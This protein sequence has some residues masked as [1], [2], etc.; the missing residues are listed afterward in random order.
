MLQALKTELTT[1]PLGRGY[2]G[3][4]NTQVVTSL[5]T[6]NRTVERRS[7]SGSQ[8]YNAIVPSEFS[9][10]LA[11]QQQLVRDVFGL[12]D[13]IDVRTGTNARAVMLA[14]FGAGTTTRA[15][16]IALVQETISRAAELGL[17]DVREGDVARARA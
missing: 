13:T 6:A 7:V 2:A 5:R 15:N 11:T 8:I 17:G 12:G 16:L 10:L 9:T 14:A 1:D 3:M 4:T